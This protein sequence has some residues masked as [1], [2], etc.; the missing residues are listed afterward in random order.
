[1]V[2]YIRAPALFH[3]QPTE[4]LL[5]QEAKFAVSIKTF[6]ESCALKDKSFQKYND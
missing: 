2:D 3:S 5:G 6:N 4:L 1:M